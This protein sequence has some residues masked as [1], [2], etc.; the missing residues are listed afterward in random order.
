MPSASSTRGTW[1]SAT[2]PITGAVTRQQG[3]QQ[4]ESRAPH[5]PQHDLIQHVRHDAGQHAHPDREQQQPGRGPHRTA[6]ERQR[7][8]QHGGHHEPDGHVVDPGAT[9]CQPLAEHDVG[10]PQGGGGE[11][12]QHAGRAAGPLHVRDQQ[13]PERGQ[14]QRAGV[15][16]AP[17]P[18]R[19]HRHRPAELDG[20]GGTQRQPRERLVERN[21]H[22]R[23]RQPEQ[24]G[25][26]QPP[27]AP[28]RQGR[29]PPRHQHRRCRQ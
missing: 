2:R 11:G 14:R 9:Y 20:D 25:Q 15:T 8:A 17:R 4:R 1:P 27:P 26:Q 23:G 22:Q 13:H 29:P 6:A 12:E 28:R 24:P 7:R 5:P 19:R 21:V 3:E 18:E 10:R 16:H